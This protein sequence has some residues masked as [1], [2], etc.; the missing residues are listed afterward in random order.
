M[1]FLAIL[2]FAGLAVAGCSKKP[3]E[4]D[5]ITPI[6]AADGSTNTDVYAERRRAGENVPELAGDQIV[7]VRTYVARKDGFGPREEIA[8]ASCK[9][10]A[11]DFSANL[12]TPAKVR[13]P[14]YRMQSSVISVRCSKAGYQTRT[15]DHSVYNKT[16]SDR[17]QM[18][19]RAG[20][21]GVIAVAAINAVSD[22]KTHDYLYPPMNITLVPLAEK[23][24]K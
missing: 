13:L 11:R 10:S 9:L 23:S 8:G 24:K 22:E 12:I 7:P 21:L 14:V 5:R 16:K 2:L 3:L 17:Y 4:V 1:R 20:V 18:G 6:R 19:G 15:V